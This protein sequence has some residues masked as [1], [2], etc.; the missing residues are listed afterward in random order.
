MLAV[1]SVRPRSTTVDFESQTQQLRELWMKSRW[2][3]QNPGW[4]VVG[5]P[6]A[7]YQYLAVIECRDGVTCVTVSQ[8]SGSCRRSSV[9]CW[10]TRVQR[11]WRSSWKLCRC[12]WHHMRMTSRPTGSML[13][14][15]DSLLASLPNSSVLSW[16]DCAKC[17]SPSG[18]YLTLHYFTHL[19][20]SQ[21]CRKSFGGSCGVT[22]LFLFLWFQPTCFVTV[23]TSTVTRLWSFF[24]YVLNVEPR[25]NI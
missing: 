3:S 22:F 6:S 18:D 17:S 4:R 19:C 25:V 24:S 9:G 7:W 14:C 1:D 20:I 16:A 15:L 2:W 21:L 5:G 8:K 13:F 11:W 10:M 23:T 12:S